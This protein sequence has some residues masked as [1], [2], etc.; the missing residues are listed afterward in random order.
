MALILTTLTGRVYVDRAGGEAGCYTSVGPAMNAFPRDDQFSYVHSVETRLHPIWTGHRVRRGE[1]QVTPFAR[2][3]T[4]RREWWS[5]AHGGDFEQRILSVECPAPGSEDRWEHAGRPDLPPAVLLAPAPGLAPGPYRVGRLELSRDELLALP[6]D[7]R[8]LFRRLEAVAGTESHSVPNQIAATL[9][10]PLTGEL[11]VALRDAL[12][13]APG[14]RLLGV[15]GGLELELLFDRGSAQLLSRRR[16][17]ADAELHLLCL[18][19]GTVVD[20][21]LCLEQAIIDHPTERLYG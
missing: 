10:T 20:E 17:V 14:V 9:T 4:E 5:A 6:T 3:A 8:L 15:R 19:L 18:P 13:L 2:V 16:I 12:A 11:R 21:Q 7:P 1:L